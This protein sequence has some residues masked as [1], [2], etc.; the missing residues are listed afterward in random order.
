MFASALMR[1]MRGCGGPDRRRSGR[2]SCRCR[3]L[4]LVQPDDVLDLDLFVKRRV[5]LVDSGLSTKTCC[6]SAR[7]KRRVDGPFTVWRSPW[8]LCPSVAGVREPIAQL[9]EDLPETLRVAVDEQH[10]LRRLEPANRSQVTAMISLSVADAPSQHDDG[11]TRSPQVGSAGRSPPP[12]RRRGGCKITLDLAGVHVLPAGEDHVLHAVD[13]VEEALVVARRRRCGT[14]HLRRG[15]VPSSL[16][17]YPLS[18]CSAPD[19]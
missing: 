12:P 15:L 19:H 11:V 9:V 13:D 17:K 2:R 1:S 6:A 5:V 10:L 8:T 18:T 14:T 7:A 4:Q 3:G 16:R